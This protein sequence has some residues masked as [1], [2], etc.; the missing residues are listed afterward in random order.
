MIRKTLSLVAIILVFGQ[1]VLAQAPATIKFGKV[2]IEDFAL[3]PSPVIDS[4]TNAVVIADIGSTIF[5]GNEKRWLSY[6]FKKKIRIKILN[7][8]GLAE[9]TVEIPLY[10][11][12]DD[13]EKLEQ[14]SASG[15]NI[16][17]GKVI[18]TKLDKKS[19]F[20]EKLDKNHTRVKFAIPS[21]KEGSIIEY[22]YTIRS[23]YDFNMPSWEFQN[24]SCP[25]LWSEYNVTIPSLITYIS[26]R[27]GYH[28]LVI[29]Q[30]DEGRENYTMKYAGPD[31]A[32]SEQMIN[33]T[34]TTVK[35]RW[36]MK[37][38]PPFGFEPF[39]S[40]PYNY[41]DRIEFQ[42]YQTF[43]GETFKDYYQTW[44]SAGEELMKSPYFGGQLKE[45]NSWLTDPLIAIEQGSNN[46]LEQV[47][48][49]YYYIQNNFTCTNNYDIYV[50]SSLAD[51]FKRKSGGVGEINL[52]LVDMLRKEG[53][54]ADPVLLSTRGAGF[55]NQ[56]YPLLEKLNYV[57]CMISLDG[58]RYYMDA[59]KPK[60]GFGK[61]PLNC[62]NGHARI[63]GGETPA[64]FFNADELKEKK[65]TNVIIINDDKAGLVGGYTQQPGYYQSLSLRERL[66][67]ANSTEYK[68]IIAGSYAENIVVS[69]IRVD[70]LTS[71]E[72]P[73]TLRYDIEF[74]MFANADNVYFNPL[75]S[76]KIIKN[77]FTAASRLYPVE[78]P[79]A[80]D[81]TFILNMEVPKGYMIDEMPKSTSISLNDKEGLFEY[82]INK[83][84]NNIQVRC[85]LVFNKA[86]YQSGDYESI[87]NFYA[88]IIRKESEVIVFKKIK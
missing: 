8:R 12:R 31:L 19:I 67:K 74:K 24:A 51:I 36:A 82:L 20:K 73:V 22:T 60:M 5:E 76:E 35:H 62:Y 29:D 63:I 34:A 55:S 77:P 43:N 75:L 6:V 26:S 45:D 17:G 66:A 58:A 1:S 49:I 18:E 65:T 3:T 4:N 69:N 68:N 11:E 44:K 23:D 33:F 86:T 71:Y 41:M 13:E 84:G 30:S 64:V 50:N 47:K 79:Y 88:D 52:L 37:D 70:S 28:N 16:E 38:I 56:K 40:S 21:V 54:N 57:V 61:L 46:K 25:T 42:E 53:I 32:K 14:L 78:M 80:T 59:S 10:I 39:T 15:Y 85:R 48:K 9:A 83:N 72:E 81:E 2:S 7:K 87:R 27:K